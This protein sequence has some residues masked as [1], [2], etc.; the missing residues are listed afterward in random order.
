MTDQSAFW[1][2]FNETPATRLGYREPTFRKMFEHLDRVA[3]P[4]CIV[5]TGC[6]RIVGNWG[7]DGQSTVM[8]DRY[9]SMR[10][11]GSVCYSVDIK[12]AS[13][14]ACRTMVS[15]RTTVIQD[16]SV[17]FLTQLNADFLKAGRTIDLLYLD[18]F[19]CDFV[20]W[21]P[22]AAHHLKEL[23]AAIR[24]LRKDTLVV[25]D[26]C[27]LAGDIVSMEGG[28]I[29]FYGDPAPGGKGRLVAE[30]A[31]AAGAKLEFAAYQ[32]GWTGF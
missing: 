23:C 25:I 16:D 26:D 20:Y 21:Q 13:V 7:G 30:Y 14:N 12:A 19:D 10:G 4:V 22:S 24:C 18:S 17:H 8:F 9:A 32:A 31:R 2:Y 5:E 11:D 3:G 6:A 29:V 27:P 15:P 28:E 1:T